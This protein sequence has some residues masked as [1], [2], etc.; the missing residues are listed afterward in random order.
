M[1]GHLPIFSVALCAVSNDTNRHTGGE[2][3]LNNASG[4][5]MGAAHT[6]R[7]SKNAGSRGTGILPVKERGRIVPESRGIGA[8]L[9]E[10]E[11]MD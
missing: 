3:L 1:K 2:M 7:R 11:M 9:K 5:Q 6:H 10:L 4:S 8:D